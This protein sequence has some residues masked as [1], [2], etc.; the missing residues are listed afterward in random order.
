M[1]ANTTSPAYAEGFDEHVG[2]MLQSV[3]NAHGEWATASHMAWLHR[4][5]SRV[6]L[7][8]LELDRRE[9]EIRRREDALRHTP[10]KSRRGK[11]G[12]QQH[13]N[14]TCPTNGIAESPA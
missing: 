9:Q 5:Y 12:G 14:T 7:R 1:A 10:Q 11:N 13:H 3:L 8:T 4:M 6:L 2:Y